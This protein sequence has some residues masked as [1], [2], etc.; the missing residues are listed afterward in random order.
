VSWLRLLVYLSPTSIHVTCG[1]LKV[2]DRGAPLDM[3]VMFKNEMM[4][5]SYPFVQT[6]L[7]P[8]KGSKVSILILI[9][10]S[11]KGICVEFE[12]NNSTQLVIP[13]LNYPLVLKVFHDWPVKYCFF[14]DFGIWLLGYSDRVQ[15][16]TFS[17]GPL[18]NK[19]LVAMTYRW[20]C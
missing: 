13:L 2:N 15:L 9:H 19:Y 20:I 14:E 11:Y 6:K 10:A 1:M 18:F 16:S 12:R 8:E 5:W 17:T 3:Y 7:F 4:S